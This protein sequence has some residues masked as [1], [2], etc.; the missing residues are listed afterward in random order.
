MG[1]TAM[2]PHCNVHKFTWISDVKTHNQIDNILIEGQQHSSVFDIL[3][4]WAANCN[5]DPYLVVAK[6]RER[7]AVKR[8]RSAQISYGEV[9]SQEVKQGRD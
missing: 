1:K 8:Q 5:T 3:S 6:V 4:F 2:L 9:Q 7:L